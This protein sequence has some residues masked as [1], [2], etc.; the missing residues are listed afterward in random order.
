[1]P[2][3]P[4]VVGQMGERQHL[5]VVGKVRQELRHIQGVMQPV[6]YRAVPGEVE[7]L[8][9]HLF[10]GHLGVDAN[11]TVNYILQ[12]TPCPQTPRNAYT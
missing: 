9:H 3:L 10:T 2:P 8:G 7:V 6:V 12:V 5:A 4:A 1:M 11:D